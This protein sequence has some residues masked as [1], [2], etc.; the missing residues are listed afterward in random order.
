MKRI[1]E[2]LISHYLPLTEDD[3]ALWDADGEEYGKVCFMNVTKNKMNV[4]YFFEDIRADINTSLQGTDTYQ[5][6]AM[7]QLKDL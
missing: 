7:I 2:C 6:K 5:S 1:C 4:C 3:L